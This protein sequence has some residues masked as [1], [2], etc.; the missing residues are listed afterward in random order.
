VQVH[1]NEETQWIHTCVPFG[2]I[3][4]QPCFFVFFLLIFLVLLTFL[5]FAFVVFVVFALFLF[6]FSSFLFVLL[7]LFF[8]SVFVVVLLL[9]LYCSYSALAQA[10]TSHI[11]NVPG[12]ELASSANYRWRIQRLSEESGWPNAFPSYSP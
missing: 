10:H 2:A 11:H 5:V 3:L 1:P 7:F 4:S 9:L 6:L 8:F 12:V